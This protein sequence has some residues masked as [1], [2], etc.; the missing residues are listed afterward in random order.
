M[1]NFLKLSTR[2]IN[3]KQISEIVINPKSYSIYFSYPLSD[4]F[5]FTFFG[6]FTSNADKI[7]I[8]SEK[9]KEDYDKVTDWIN[10]IK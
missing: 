8:D 6:S 9:N 5:M 4:G 7:T 3:T 10:N 2:I 1:H